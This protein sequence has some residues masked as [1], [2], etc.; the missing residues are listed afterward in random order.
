MKVFD[1]NVTPADV[2]AHEDSIPEYMKMYWEHM[3]NFMD[4][5]YEINTDSFTKELAKAYGGSATNAWR[6]LAWYDWCG[7]GSGYINRERLL[8]VLKTSPE[9]DYFY[10]AFVV[11]KPSRAVY[12]RLKNTQYGEFY[13]AHSL[14]YRLMSKN[15]KEDK[16]PLHLDSD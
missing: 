12:D 14:F 8:A 10:H 11:R 15:G 6:T 9:E 16:H 3:N 1:K 4:T 2:K 7:E 5:V 13:I